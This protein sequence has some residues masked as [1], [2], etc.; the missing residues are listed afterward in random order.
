MVLKFEVELLVIGIIIF[1]SQ[2]MTRCKPSL[3]GFAFGKVPAGW[4]IKK[5][6]PGVRAM[7]K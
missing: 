7:T 3:R 5:E 2:R 1:V 4:K 6:W